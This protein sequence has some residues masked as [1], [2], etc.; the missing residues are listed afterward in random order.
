MSQP[1]KIVSYE[2]LPLIPPGEPVP[3][4]SQPLNNI[5]SQLRSIESLLEAQRAQDVELY[6]QPGDE[7]NYIGDTQTCTA[8]AVTTITWTFLPD[9]IYYFKKIYVDKQANMSYVWT[10]Q[11]TTEATGA[12]V[13][14]GNEHD[15]NGKL[16]KGKGNTTLKLAMTNT[17]STAM[18]HDIVIQSWA[19]R[20]K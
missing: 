2:P 13:L 1:C 7:D 19:R 16:V 12:K 17:G 18:E 10:F 5:N 4:Y 20:V 6:P 8:S 11:A 15:F 9:Y 14:N 3:D